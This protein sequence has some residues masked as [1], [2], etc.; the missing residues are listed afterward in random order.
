MSASQYGCK[1]PL[2]AKKNYRVGIINPSS[3][4][5]EVV[6]GFK[7]GMA[8]HGYR[9]GKNITYLEHNPIK[10]A[11]VDTTIQ[12]MLAS[13]IDL[14]F[15]TTTPATLKAK[16]AVA[17]TKVPVVFTPVFAPV[18]SGIVTSLSMPDGNLTGVR[19]GGSIAKTLG[20]LLAVRP[21]TKK[22]FVPL[23]YEDKAASSTLND[24][25]AAAKK[26]AIEVD[27]VNITTKEDLEKA[28]A[29]IPADADSVWLSCSTLLFSNLKEIVAVATAHDLPVA[30]STHQQA[31]GVLVSYGV[32]FSLLGQQAS[33]MA[34]KI[35]QGASPADLPVETAEFF[36]GVN[37]PK[38][39]ELGITI[40]DDII[41]QADF[42]VR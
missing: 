18:E 32:N 31:E 14:L 11:K 7:K 26:F 28:L 37:L 10:L 34:D 30:S 25:T 21:Q 12:S 40:P 13:G 23:P 29:Q 6:T 5:T 16:R 39:R 35:L 2:A 9:D 41:E 4:L 15:V 8:A 36:L 42:V 22:I 33:R 38:G 3:G 17:G 24:L 27:A 1:H 20:W 19:V